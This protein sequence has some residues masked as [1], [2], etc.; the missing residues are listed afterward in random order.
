MNGTST[1]CRLCQNKCL[2]HLFQQKEIEAFRNGGAK[3][4]RFKKGET[5]IKQGSFASHILFLKEGLVKLVLESPNNKESI[6]QLAAPDSFVCLSTLYIDD[7]FPFS[8]VALKDCEVCIIKRDIL[9][10]QLINDLKAAEFILSLNS[11][12]SLYL[13]K[14]MS[15][16]STRN[17]HGK[18]ADALLYLSKDEFKNQ[19]IHKHLTRNDIAELASIS[20]E[21]TN[22]IFNELKNDL[23]IKISS[24]GLEICNIDLIERLSRIG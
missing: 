21:S 14:R 4:I 3:Q 1:D 22:K 23:I 13:L 8:V 16:Q 6:F 24:D 17:S 15:V 19:N 7:Y 18:L 9:R 20:L 12:E 11:K 2:H 5:I 10:Q